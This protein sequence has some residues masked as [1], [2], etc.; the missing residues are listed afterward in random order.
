MA[1]DF[2]DE[3]VLGHVFGFKAVATDGGVGASQVSLVSREGRG[4]RRQPKRIWGVEGL[5][6]V[7]TASGEAK[8]LRER[9]LASSAM[10]FF[11]SARTGIGHDVVPPS[12]D[13]ASQWAEEW[14]RKM[15]EDA[16]DVI[17]R[18]IQRLDTSRSMLPAEGDS[19]K[20]GYK[21]SYT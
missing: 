6:V 19:R 15:D 3:D 16:A 2:C 10:M 17:V 7:L 18:V 9:S 12:Y 11:G 5:V 13:L 1:E 14:V 21:Y 4:S 8:L 20:L